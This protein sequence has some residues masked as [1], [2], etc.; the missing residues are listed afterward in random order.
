MIS[1]IKNLFFKR[2]KLTGEVNVFT[3]NISVSERPGMSA[4]RK[5]LQ[6]R[7]C[8]N[9]KEIAPG[10]PFRQYQTDKSAALLPYLSAYP[11]NQVLKCEKHS[12]LHVKRVPELKATAMRKRIPQPARRY[13]ASHHPSRLPQC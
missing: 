6:W 1:L 12:L 5:A 10:H 7:A 2:L 8:T 4:K 3:L 13:S 11:I 9:L